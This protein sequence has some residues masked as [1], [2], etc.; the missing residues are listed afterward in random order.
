MLGRVG[1]TSHEI[2]TLKG[3]GKTSPPITVVVESAVATNSKEY[4]PASK[5]ASF[6]STT[7]VV[8]SETLH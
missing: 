5:A 2:T 1:V 6:V 7:S 3:I 8:G 4:K